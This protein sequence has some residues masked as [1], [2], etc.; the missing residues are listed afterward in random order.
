LDFS[1]TDKGITKLEV[2]WKAEYDN[3]LPMPDRP[4]G[5]TTYPVENAPAQIGISG[6]NFSVS[7]DG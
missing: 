4:S 6:G 2:N 1:R 5:S 7:F 3:P